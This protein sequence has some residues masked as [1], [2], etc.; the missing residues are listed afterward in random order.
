LNM[1][2]KTDKEDRGCD[3]IAFLFEIITNSRYDKK[4]T[5]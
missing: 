5:I 3:D 1:N 2:S 4:A